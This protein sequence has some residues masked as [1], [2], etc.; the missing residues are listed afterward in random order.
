[1]ATDST[2]R[3]LAY[4]TADTSFG[5]GGADGQVVAT[6]GRGDVS[7]YVLGAIVRTYKD[8]LGTWYVEYV[9]FDGARYIAPAASIDFATSEQL[10]AVARRL[11][12]QFAKETKHVGPVKGLDTP[13]GAGDDVEAYRG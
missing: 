11:A 13:A 9:D 12:Y 10:V 2:N 5:K 8:V 3:L 4:L 1:M 6:I 7:S